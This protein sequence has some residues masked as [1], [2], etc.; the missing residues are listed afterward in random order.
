MKLWLVKAGSYEYDTVGD[1]V[2][3]A[4]T[5]EQAIELFKKVKYVAPGPYTARP[6]TLGSRAR[7]IHTQYNAG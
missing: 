5:Q 3:W 1:G 6:V 4:S 7:V 2:V